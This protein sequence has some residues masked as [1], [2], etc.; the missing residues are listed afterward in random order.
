MSIA[1][2]KS[3]TTL[4]LDID[5][6]ILSNQPGEGPSE[7]SLKTG[8][9]DFLEWA[10]KEFDCYWLTAWAVDGE[11]ADIRHDLD[12]FLPPSCRGLSVA[13][14]NRLKIEAFEQ[15]DGNFLWADDS[16]LQA[17]YKWLDEHD[18]SDRVVLAKTTD[19]TIDAIENEIKKKAKFL[20]ER[21]GYLGFPKPPGEQ[22]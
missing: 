16:V 13:R 7:K 12:P 15:E 10:V 14:W 3:K 18:W 22:R 2:M 8:T 5:G 1:H 21:P 4:Y 17:E 6:T 20:Q 19:P 9:V 11:E